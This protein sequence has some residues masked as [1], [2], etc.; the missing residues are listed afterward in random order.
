MHAFNELD[1]GE[2]HSF[3][4]CPFNCGEGDAP[5]GIAGNVLEQLGGQRMTSR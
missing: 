1:V 2:E 4:P 5:A 3:V